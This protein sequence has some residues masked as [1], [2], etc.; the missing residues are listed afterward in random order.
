ML[1]AVK[2]WHWN[3]CERTHITSAGSLLSSIDNW[4]MDLSLTFFQITTSGTTT[5]PVQ[6]LTMDT[7]NS[8][9]HQNGGSHSPISTGTT[10]ED[11]KTNLIVNY[12]PQGMTQEEIRSLFSSL[13]EVESCKLIRDKTTGTCFLQLS[14]IAFG[15]N[16]NQKT[17]SAL[18]WPTHALLASLSAI[19][20]RIHRPWRSCRC[21]SA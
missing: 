19:F 3:V 15:T 12:L 21:A 7:T 20:M 17:S 9:V 2:I 13:G 14:G 5:E 11:S 1:S 10:A 8:T 18:G 6:V 16:M 4:L